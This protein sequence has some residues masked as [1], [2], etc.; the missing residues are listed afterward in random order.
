MSNPLSY[1]AYA[2]IPADGQRWEFLDGG[3]FVTPTPSPAH[4]FA[5]LRL[6]RF[7]ED[8]RAHFGPDAI[9]FVAPI[10]VILNDNEIVQPDVVVARRTQLSGRGIE[11]APLLLVEVISPARPALDRDV[12]ARRYAANR[13][14]RYWLVD[15]AVRTVECFHLAGDAYAPVASARGD[16]R[17]DVPDVPGVALHLDGLWLHSLARSMWRCR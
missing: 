16:E 1:A 9:A 10:E 14:E 13:V 8:H 17:L 11:G 3:V 6:G 2:E 7:L 4:Q 12:K 5:V 15:P